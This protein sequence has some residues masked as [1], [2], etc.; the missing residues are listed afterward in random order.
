MSLQPFYV[1]MWRTLEN[2]MAASL[3]TVPLIFAAWVVASC[4][5]WAID[6]QDRFIEFLGDNNTETYDLST[7]QMIVPGRF[8]IISTTID[9]P[10]VM[11][12]ELTVLGTLQGYCMR[13]DGKYPAPTKLLALG[14]A[15]MPVKTINVE[16]NKKYQTRTVDWDYPYKRLRLK[17][18]PGW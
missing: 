17:P 7:V 6:D 11:K 10:D 5:S 3:K 14:P 4:P 1:K 2:A 16:N 12:F 13:P 15:D 8:T 9:N 18:L